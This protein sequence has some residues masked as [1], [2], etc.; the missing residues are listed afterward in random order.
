MN[1]TFTSEQIA[2]I[3]WGIKPKPVKQVPQFYL[4]RYPFNTYD[5]YVEDLHEFLNGQ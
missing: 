3:V 5:D 2:E 1:K 4:D